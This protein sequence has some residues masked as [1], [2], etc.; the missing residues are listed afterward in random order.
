MKVLH[1]SFECY[2]IAK[3]GGLADVVGSLPAYQTKLGIEADVVMPYYSNTFVQKQKKIE[4][5][6]G[7]ISVGSKEYEYKI[8]NIVHFLDLYNS[9]K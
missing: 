6:S 3:V 5:F 2:P 8:Y 7:N 4:I 9:N 1:N